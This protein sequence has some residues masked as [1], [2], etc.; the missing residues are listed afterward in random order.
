MLLWLI[1]RLELRT[2]D[3]LFIAINDSVNREFHFDMMLAKEYPHL[4]IHIVALKFDTRGAAETL[5]IVSQ[6]MTDA[7]S[8]RRTV[9]LDCDTIYFPEAQ[10]LSRVRLLPESQGATVVFDDAGDPPVFSCA[11][12]FVSQSWRRSLTTPFH[13]DV[14]TD[15]RNRIV[16]IKEKVAISRKANTGAYIFPNGFQLRLGAAAF[17]DQAVDE[18]ALGEVSFRLGFSQQH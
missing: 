16:Q 18:L 6:S 8:A 2:T 13:A 12:V 1:D 14:E 3:S 4:D 17:L 11:S 7:Q 5:F 10:L 9:S 15:S